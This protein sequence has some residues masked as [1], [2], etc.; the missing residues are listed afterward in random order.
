MLERFQ[1]LDAMREDLQRAGIETIDE[2]AVCQP[3]EIAGTLD[4]P[5]EQAA[6]LVQLSQELMMAIVDGEDPD[7]IDEG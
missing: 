7:S 5:P 1:V 2:I 6:D 4:L 3:K